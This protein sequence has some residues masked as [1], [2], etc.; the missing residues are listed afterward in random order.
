M[1]EKLNIYKNLHS[2]VM[3]PCIGNWQLLYC[4]MCKSQFPYCG[5][6][7]P[8]YEEIHLLEAISSCFLLWRTDRNKSRRRKALPL[9]YII[10]PF[11][12]SQITFSSITSP[13][14]YEMPTRIKKWA[15]ICPHYTFYPFSKGD[16]FYRI[17]TVKCFGEEY[18][19][20]FIFHLHF[21]ASFK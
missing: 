4:C 11:S 21:L 13:Q 19:K 1:F 15:Y 14:S 10:H 3:G 8:V 2:M 18:F 9:L 7:G 16:I 20:H 5:Y 6:P 17:D 12:L